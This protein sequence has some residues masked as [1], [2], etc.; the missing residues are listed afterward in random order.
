MNWI[1]SC[2]GSGHALDRVIHW[3]GST[4]LHKKHKLSIEKHKLSI[5]KQK[6]SIEKHKLSIEKHKLSIEKHKLIHGGSRRNSPDTEGGAG[7]F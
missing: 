1:G 6:L 5:E 3:I 4:G 2:I 7:P